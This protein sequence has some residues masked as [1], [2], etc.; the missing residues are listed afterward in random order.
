M[1]GI[2]LEL[3]RAVSEEGEESE[4]AH[5]YSVVLLLRFWERNNYQMIFQITSFIFLIVLVDF[6]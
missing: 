4:H 3:G 6:P 5:Y 1:F 2:E